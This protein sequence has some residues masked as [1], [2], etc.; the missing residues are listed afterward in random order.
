MPFA[1]RDVGAHLARRLDEA[2][3][4]GLGEDHDEQRP[5]RLAYGGQSGNIAQIAENVG[6]LNDDAGRAGIDLVGEI[7]PRQNIGREADHVVARHRR[8]GA[9][10]LGVVRMQA[11]REHRLSP[12]RDAVSHQHRLDRRGRTVIHRGVGDIHR[13]QGRNLSLKLENRL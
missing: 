2:E 13:G 3:R 4:H 11:A 8:N 9:H 6:V 5:L 10:D 7:F 12:L 1:D